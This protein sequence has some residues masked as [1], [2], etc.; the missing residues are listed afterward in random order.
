MND[1]E[2]EALLAGEDDDV[3]PLDNTELNA[4]SSSGSG[5]NRGGGGRGKRITGGMTNNG[6]AVTYVSPSDAFHML[7][8]GQ[9]GQQVEDDDPFD[10][11]CDDLDDDDD[12]MGDDDVDALFADDYD[13]SGPRRRNPRN[14]KRT[15]LDCFGCMFTS[16][17]DSQT[18]ADS[19][20]DG[21]KINDLL[22]IFDDNVGRIDLKVIARLCHLF[23]KTEIY[24]PLAAKGVPVPMWR[25]RD[26]YTHFYDHLLDPRL[27]LLEQLTEAR[28]MSRTLRRMSFA[29]T[30]S[31]TLATMDKTIDK[32]WR[33]NTQMVTLYKTAPESLNFHNP[34]HKI[35]FAV[36][37]KLMGPHRN[38]A[39]ENG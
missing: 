8:S 36:M 14:R 17:G 5:G 35:D 20:I 24:L 12:R 23:F 10:T 27:F 9:S 31:G 26:I 39:I 25:T 28:A 33:T 22:K 4:V 1:A 3:Y 29:V 21:G 30:D 13:Y 38:F 19:Q 18:S 34:T 37:S 7:N 16:R 32:L 2:L 11:S 15:S 6:E